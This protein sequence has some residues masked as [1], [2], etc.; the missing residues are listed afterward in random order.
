MAGRWIL[1]LLFATL[2]L[3]QMGVGHTRPLEYPVDASTSD[4]T[5]DCCDAS[6]EESCSRTR[7]K[8][9]A[10]P[11]AS[12]CA[13]ANGLVNINV[14]ISGMGVTAFAAPCLS[15]HV[16]FPVRR[17][18][19]TAAPAAISSTPLIYHLQRLLN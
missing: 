1:T 14:A 6:H 8:Y 7:N 2:G 10:D 17:P 9:S 13:Q 16:V 5:S 18:T 3:V 12:V 15:G 4:L 19:L 11:C